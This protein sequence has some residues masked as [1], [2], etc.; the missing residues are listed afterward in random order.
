[1]AGVK[2]RHRAVRRGEPIQFFTPAEVAERLNVNIR[3]VRR[4]ISAGDLVVHRVRAVVRIAPGRKPPSRWW[5][6]MTG[7]EAAF[8]GALTKHADHRIRKNGMPFTLLSVLVG[9]RPEQLP[10]RR[11]TVLRRDHGHRL[12]CSAR[13]P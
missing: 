8:C 9:G 7:I 13:V 11:S 6:A 12:R 10:Q 2:A 4:W 3:T 5:R 1:M